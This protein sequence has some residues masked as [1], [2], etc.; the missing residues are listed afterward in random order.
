MGVTPIVSDLCKS[1]SIQEWM[2]LLTFF[3]LLVTGIEE[4]P[5]NMGMGNSEKLIT[6]RDGVRLIQRTEDCHPGP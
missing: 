6:L 4:L 2:L 3:L 1:L 5:T